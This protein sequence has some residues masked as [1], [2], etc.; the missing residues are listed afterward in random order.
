M[1]RLFLQGNIQHVL[2]SRITPERLSKVQPGSAGFSFGL[3][4]VGSSGDLDRLAFGE[5]AT[6]PG[7][8]AVVPGDNPDSPAL[9]RSDESPFFT[10]FR[11][12]LQGIEGL[13]LRR[14]D[15]DSPLKSQQLWERIVAE[16]EG[17]GDSSTPMV[18]AVMF[19]EFG[20]L[21]GSYVKQSP[22]AGNAPIGGIPIIDP[23][24]H[25]DWFGV[26][27]DGGN[28]SLWAMVVGVGLR[29][30]ETLRSRLAGRDAFIF[31]R[32]PDAP[33]SSSPL[34][35]HQHALIMD[36]VNAPKE[37]DVAGVAASN[38]LAER[39]VVDVKHVLE[40]SVVRRAWVAEVGFDEIHLDGKQG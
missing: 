1:I 18:G 17:R 13:P 30:D 23:S 15:L 25:S 4:A 31:Y 20:G 21:R 37:G 9:A 29:Q 19:V 11:V 2:F 28:G 6:A 39:E 35:V 40:D 10:P 22:V 5:L 36:G 24:V 32:H 12:V 33:P 8:A 14:I 26:I 34:V 16:A 3:G 38:W 7:L 27:P